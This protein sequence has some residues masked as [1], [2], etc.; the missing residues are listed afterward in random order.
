MRARKYGIAAAFLS[1]FLLAGCWDQRELSTISVVTGMAVDKG[2]KGKYILTIEAVNA[3]ELNNKTASGFAPSTVYGLEGDSMEGLAQK[4]NVAFSRNLIYSHM[5]TFIISEE[6]AKKGMLDFL[7]FLERDREIRDDFNILI[8]KGVKASDILRVTYQFQKSSPLKLHAQLDSMV[9]NWG[10]DPDV[11]LNDMIEALTSTGREPVMATVTIKGNPQKGKSIENMQKVT[12][13]ALVI[14]D[15]MAIFK[16]QKL[17]GYLNLNDTRNYIWIEDKLKHTSLT[18]PCKKNQYF[19]ARV[20][21]NGTKVD[22]YLDNGKARITVSVRAEAYLNGTQCAADLVKIEVYKKYE[23]MLEKTIKKNLLNTITK[24]Q[25]QY[26]LDIFG[27]G[28]KVR[29]QDYQDYKKIENNWGH[30]FKNAE[31]KVNVTARIRRSGIRT[32]SYLTNIKK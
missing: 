26:G 16:S 7:D 2:E 30:Y 24:V 14:L 3:Q 25:E 5:K 15:S 27:F 23:D 32:K 11:R 9:K 8:A 18:V 31:I 28:E 10:G 19:D 13:D 1:V 6:I 17:K 12:P 4:M 20:Y 29:Q 21:D 22:G